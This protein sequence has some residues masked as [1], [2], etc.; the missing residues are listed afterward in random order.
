MINLR[1]T[2]FCQKNMYSIP[3]ALLAVKSTQSLCIH[4]PGTGRPA[5]KL[6]RATEFFLFQ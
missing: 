5:Y 6:Q 4:F 3:T 1:L 2:N